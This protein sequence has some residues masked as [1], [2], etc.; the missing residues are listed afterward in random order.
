MKIPKHKRSTKRITKEIFG[1]SWRKSESLRKFYANDS[2]SSKN[3]M[4]AENRNTK[5]IQKKS[6]VA[7]GGNPKV[8]GGFMQTPPTRDHARGND[9]NL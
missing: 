7:V 3:T 2:F 1:G 8:Y 9:S 5:E 6:S 4:K